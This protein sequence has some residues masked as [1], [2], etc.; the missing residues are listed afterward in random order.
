MIVLHARVPIRPD[1]REDFLAGLPPLVS[2]SREEQGNRSY[3]CYE[4]TETE[5]LFCFVEQWESMEALPSFKPPPSGSRLW[6]FLELFSKTNVWLYRRSGG[7]IGGRMGRAPVLLLHHVGR[8]SGKERV[9]PVLFLADDDRLVIVGS[10]GGA[11]SHPALFINLMASPRTTVE[12]GSRRF[13]VQAREAS[14]TERVAYWPRLLEIY[15]SYGTYRDRT[16][17][18]LP[19]VVLEPVDPA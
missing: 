12:V 1:K 14:E 8:K 19:V 16:Q 17:R 6:R 13:E 15:P 11:A 2:A 7:R 3:E 10:T 18:V 9:S 5:N 4:S